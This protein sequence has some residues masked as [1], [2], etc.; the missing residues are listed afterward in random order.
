MLKVIEPGPETVVED[1]PGRRGLCYMCM[2]PAGAMDHLAHRAANLVVGNPLGEAGLEIAGGLFEAGFGSDRVICITGGDMKI[3]INDQVVP[4]WESIRVSK[5]DKITFGSCGEFGFRAYLAIS[6]GIDVPIYW[7]SKSTC[8]MGQY[9]G[10]ENRPL[11]EGDELK[12]GQPK[13]GLRNLENRKFKRKLIPE[14]SRIWE[15]QSVPGPLA[16]PDYI[17]EEGMEWLFSHVFQVTSVAARSAIRLKADPQIFRKI[18]AREG[19][20]MAGRHPSNIQDFPYVLPGGVNISGDYPIILP[21]DAPTFG[22][23]MISH[24]VIYADA[25]K[26]GQITPLRDSL[27]FVYCTPEVAIEARMKQDRLFTEE[28]IE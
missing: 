18:F 26:L 17:T 11:K 4:M 12:L 3:K 5:G 16:A 13:Q 7:G 24:S 2:P 10:F 25:W 1:W 28:E 14:Y 9:G 20:G 6:G 23:Y 27:K 19:G 21:N 15:L 22:G 8:V